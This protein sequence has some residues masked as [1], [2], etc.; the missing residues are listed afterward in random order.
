MKE[1]F[2][3]DMNV[4]EANNV[5]AKEAI[6]AGRCPITFEFSNVS[7]QMPYAMGAALDA[8]NNAKLLEKIKDDKK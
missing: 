2:T 8:L 4:S 7:A 6:A 3:T 1:S 5:Y